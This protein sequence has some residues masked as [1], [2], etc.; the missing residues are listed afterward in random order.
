MPSSLRLYVYS[1]VTRFWIAKFF[2]E[3]DSFLH[4]KKT[5][6]PARNGRSWWKL[7]IF[8]AID[9]LAVS[10]MM[11]I[12]TGV[13]SFPACWTNSFPSYACPFLLLC[14]CDRFYCFFWI[15]LDGIFITTCTVAETDLMLF[16]LW[17]I[18]CFLFPLR[19]LLF[20]VQNSFCLKRRCPLI[21][22]SL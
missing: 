19:F 2:T 1:D 18:K 14:S 3:I 16:R 5:H 22:H 17:R 4:R 6:F 8:L 21:S 12:V 11:Q 9:A 13:V 7:M 10:L 15:Q 20:I